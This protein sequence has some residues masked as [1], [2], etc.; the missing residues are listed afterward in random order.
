MGILFLVF[1][2]YKVFGSR[3]VF[4]G[5]FQGWIQQFLADGSAYPFMVPILRR[6]VLPH[7]LA[8]ALLVSY[9]EL[10][11]GLSLV[12]G[13]WVRLASCWGL[14]YMLAPVWC[15]TRPASPPIPTTMP[16]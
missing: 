10:A 16:T 15:V 13:L 4:G 6:I 2:E 5:G 1:G 11:I 8:I 3:F 7:G 12:L 9:G 14:V